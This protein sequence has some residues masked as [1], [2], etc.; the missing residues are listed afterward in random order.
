M[1]CNKSTSEYYN[2]FV[3]T[4]IVFIVKSCIIWLLFG[5]LILSFIFSVALLLCNKILH[6]EQLCILAISTECLY[7][8]GVEAYYSIQ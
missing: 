7:V 3:G 6:K 4:D 8:T 2:E 1:P 5:C